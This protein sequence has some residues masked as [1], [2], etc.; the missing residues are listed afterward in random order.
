M[1][2][3]LPAENPE[4]LTGYQILVHTISGGEKP[5]QDYH[6]DDLN[7]ATQGA[8]TEQDAARLQSLVQQRK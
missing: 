3:I 8:A 6:E 4:L 5:D 2:L 1:T 7:A